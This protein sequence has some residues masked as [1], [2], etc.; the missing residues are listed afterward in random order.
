MTLVLI[1]LGIGALIGLLGAGGSILAVPAL[2]Y[3]AGLPL[4]EAIPTSLVVVGV[5]ATVAAAPRVK[6]RLVRWPVAGAFAVAGI[7]AAFVGAAVNRALDPRVVLVGFALVMV[8]A[9]VRMLSHQPAVAASGCTTE[10][11]T[12]R[13]RRCLPRSVGAGAAVG[14]L[15]GLF[16]VGGGFLVVPALVI[17]IGLPMAV[18]VG[19]SLVVVA[20]N[21]AA[22]FAAHAA[23]GPLDPGTV[24]TFTIASVVAASVAALLAARVP[25]DRL[26]RW[27]AYLVLAVAAFVLAASALQP[28]AAG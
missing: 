2:V 14:F 12:V 1:G 17:L 27:F 10:T 23:D 18:A 8:A 22:G 16:G 13:W 15:T 7:P 28:Q 11:G 6:Q 26:R 24:L 21:S 25:A 3:A 9:A 19:T 5:S 4:A 20:V